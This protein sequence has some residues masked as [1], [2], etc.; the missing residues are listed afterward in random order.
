MRPGC[1]NVGRSPEGSCFVPSGK[2]AMIITE[3]MENGSLDS[4]LRVG[5]EAVKVPV[6][7][8]SHY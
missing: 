1:F 4:F 8:V 6:C 3:Y 2:P 5:I 7:F